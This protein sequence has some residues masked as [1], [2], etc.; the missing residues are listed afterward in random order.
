MSI[1]MKKSDV[2]E[3]FGNNSKIAK[4]LG[5]TRQAVAKWKEYVPDLSAHKLLKEHP[6]LKHQFQ[7]T[8]KP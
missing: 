8:K 7:P 1:I 2:L 4:Q 3:E 5:I 6:H